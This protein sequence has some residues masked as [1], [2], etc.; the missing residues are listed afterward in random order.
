MICR[1]TA[2]YVVYWRGV[3][4]DK[5]NSLAI[6]IFCIIIKKTLTVDFTTPVITCNF[7]VSCLK[8]MQTC[9]QPQARGN[10]KCSSNS[11]LQAKRHFQNPIFRC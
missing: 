9:E 6:I 3:A 1:P 5:C 2:W 8:Y 10:N 11:N 7:I 4:I